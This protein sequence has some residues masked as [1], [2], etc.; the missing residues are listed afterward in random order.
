M[1]K[2][3]GHSK[4]LQFAID[5]YRQN[6]GK[7]QNEHAQILLVLRAIESP[8]YTTTCTP[9]LSQLELNVAPAKDSLDDLKQ[10]EDLISDLWLRTG[11]TSPTPDADPRVVQRPTTENITSYLHTMALLIYSSR[12]ALEYLA[13]MF[14][15]WVHISKTHRGDLFRE[16]DTRQEVL[17][18]SLALCYEQQT[19]NALMR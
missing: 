6:L 18:C 16:M 17:W 5:F 10:I 15:L 2:K 19:W 7:I 8:K 11:A 12:T 9:E 1:P 4:K 14:S 3:T 13:R